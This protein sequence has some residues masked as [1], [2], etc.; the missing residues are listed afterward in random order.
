MIGEP[1]V[2]DFCLVRAFRWGTHVCATVTTGECAA[3]GHCEYEF[4][5]E[6]IDKDH[7][8]TALD[9]PEDLF[10]RHP[11]EDDDDPLDDDYDDEDDAPADEDD[12]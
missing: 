11:D 12:E 3:C 2:C 1:L 4:A 8:M 5:E 6:S 10:D 9:R 7:A